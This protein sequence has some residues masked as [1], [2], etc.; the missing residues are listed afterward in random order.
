[1]K[2]SVAASFY[3]LIVAACTIPDIGAINFSGCL[4]ECTAMTD[5]HVTVVLQSSESCG[6]LD[7]ECW[8][9]HTEELA[10]CFTQAMECTAA[11][12]EQVED[13]LK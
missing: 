6:E 8:R 11:C 10:R 12:S 7:R 9:T 4:R 3:V 1:M 2:L 5:R 13:Q